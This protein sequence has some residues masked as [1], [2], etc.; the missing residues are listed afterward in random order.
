MTASAGFYP[1]ENFPQPFSLSALFGFRKDAQPTWRYEAPSQH[2]N[3]EPLDLCTCS[4]LS[5]RCYRALLTTVASDRVSSDSSSPPHLVNPTG[6]TTS[7]TKPSP[8]YASPS[9]SQNVPRTDAADNRTN[10][11]AGAVTAGQHVQHVHQAAA[12]TP[13][14]VDFET[15]FEIFRASIAGAED[16]SG[17]ERGKL[18][19]DVWRSCRPP[20]PEAWVYNVMVIRHLVD[21]EWD[22]VRIL[23]K[24]KFFAIPPTY[25]EESM[26][27]LECLEVAAARSLHASRVY[28]RIYMKMAEAAAVAEASKSSS[29]DLELACIIRQ[30]LQGAS[31]QSGDVKPL[32][33]DTLS[34]VA[35]KIH[36]LHLRKSLH[37]ILAG[38]SNTE[39]SIT[40]LL[41]HAAKDNSL[42]TAVEHVLYCLP[43]QH[44][45]P[46]VPSITTSLIK[47][48]EW[49]SRLSDDT[50]RNRLSAWLAILQRLDS[51]PE[52][53]VAGTSHLAAA[54]AA[55]SDHVFGN[56]NPG[57]LRP[58]ILLH[59]SV[60]KLMQEHPLHAPHKERLLRSI[61]SSSNAPPHGQEG[62]KKLEPTLVTILAQIRRHSL[63]SAQLTNITVDL[64]TRHT[65]ILSVYRLLAALDEEGLTLDD[66]SSIELLITEKM[67]FIQHRTASLTETQRQHRTFALRTCQKILA[68]LSKH[69]AASVAPSLLATMQEKLHTLQA[70]RQFQAILDRAEKNHALP[71][72][73]RHVT[74]DAPDDQ[75]NILIHQLA[76]H[77]SLGTARSHRETW[78]AIYYLY[79]YL[80]EHSFPIGPLF[81]KAVV[82][83]S[84]IRPLIEQRFVSARRLIWVCQ[85]VARVEGEDVAR[86]IEN[87]FHRWRGGLI[88]HAKE[89]HDDADGDRKAKAHVGVM[90]RLGLI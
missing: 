8:V 77:Y 13:D 88:K 15:Y 31:S 34:A 74:A 11:A 22:P 24:L 67:A 45:L 84:I 79:N 43:R 46:L 70:Q 71:Q 23:S 87:D 18:L 89:V 21:L 27:F 26:G 30:S 49:K 41:A 40:L 64:F 2:H 55:V 85:L 39:Q 25:V 54:V 3:A 86:K 47:A 58:H 80:Q 61:Y 90:K 19:L 4:R 76:H 1:Q 48:V 68:I 75:R 35:S 6:R 63:P 83:V 60:F 59:A 38:I 5:T 62:L 9:F 82:R 50:Y 53:G 32:V 28:H 16:L 69:T 14:T 12:D 57:Q 29:Q 51:K 10:L 17:S 52:S 20:H 81:T 73:Y 36:H 33:A 44:V 66:P 65:N 7:L 37:S 42:Y 56:S 78:R 72:A